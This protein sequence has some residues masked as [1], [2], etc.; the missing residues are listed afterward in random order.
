MNILEIRNGKGKVSRG[1]EKVVCD[2]NFDKLLL[3]E[4]KGLS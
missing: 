2:I 4:I 3:W 1:V